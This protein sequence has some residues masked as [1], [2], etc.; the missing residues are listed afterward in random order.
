[1]KTRKTVI[2]VLSAALV[3][4]LII[5]CSAL[6]DS[7][8]LDLVK[9][10]QIAPPGK[11]LVRFNLMNLNSRTILPDTSA[12]T[13][14]NDFD[15]FTVEILDGSAVDVTP[16]ALQ[17]DLT[18]TELTTAFP[19]DSGDTY[20]FTVIAWDDSTIA[21]AL[22][23]GTTSLNLTTAS[24]VNIVLKEIVNGVDEGLFAWDVVTTFTNP[25]GG[26]TVPY[27]T[28]LLTLIDLSSG[29]PVTTL[30][31]YD[32]LT[33]SQNQ[34]DESVPSG[35]YKMVIELGRTAGAQ[36]YQTVYV[37]DMIHIWAG[38]TSTYD[39]TLPNL[40]STYHLVEYEYNDAGNALIGTRPDVG[41]THG[42][43]IPAAHFVPANNPHTTATPGPA[44]FMFGGW[45]TDDTTFL[46][47]IT[48]ASMIIKPL[49]LYAKW[50]AVT[51]VNVDFDISVGFSTG[52]DPDIFA[53]VTSYNQTANSFNILVTINNTSSFDTFEWYDDIDDTT[54]IGTS[55]SGTP[56]FTLTYALA[57][58]TANWWQAGAHVLTLVVYDSTDLSGMKYSAEFT[59]T[60]TP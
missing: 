37:Q 36:T 50:N 31:G 38:F 4:A 23:L 19:L 21:V 24:T 34:G 13:D 2:T 58:G 10:E 22:A 33:G 48:A 15:H 11:T 35:Y 47:Q 6:L 57:A 26:A 41:V 17:G 52:Y 32:L 14:E 25:L 53:A 8:S 56:T 40:R 28:A 44:T 20:E 27:T 55:T 12:I 3:I 46:N 7:S 51:S 42:G 16:A 9:E 49:N 29:D 54:P 60:C 45:Y 5:S 43:N 1:M 18:L 39:K 59:V 30:D